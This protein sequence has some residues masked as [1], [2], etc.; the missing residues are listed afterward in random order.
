MEML[1]GLAVMLAGPV[2]VA[3]GRI[4][5]VLVLLTGLAVSVFW[6][7]KALDARGYDPAQA[8]SNGLS[9]QGECHSDPGEPK[10]RAAGEHS[11]DIREQVANQ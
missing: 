8:V 7:V 2:T 4:E 10:Q 6:A 9:V 5:G 3:L 11:A 1:L